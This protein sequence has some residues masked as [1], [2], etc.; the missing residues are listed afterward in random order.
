MVV[1]MWSELLP[2]ERSARALQAGGGSPE[3]LFEGCR[4]LRSLWDAVRLEVAA[5]EASP[6]VLHS[7]TQLDP[8][9][10]P[11]EVKDPAGM[12]TWGVGGAERSCKELARVRTTCKTRVRVLALS[13]LRPGLTRCQS[14]PPPA[15]ASVCWAAVDAGGAGCV[16]P[17]SE[18]FGLALRVAFSVTCFPGLG[19]TGALQL[20]FL[21]A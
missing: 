17:A 1:L 2:E 10:P 13:A 12:Q 18:L 7:F 9:L 19:L 16:N 15:L 20:G 21:L 8:D 4:R 14:L 11:L 5:E 6:V 3:R